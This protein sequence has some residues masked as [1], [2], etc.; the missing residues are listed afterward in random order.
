MTRET[1][2]KANVRRSV[3]DAK[4]SEKTLTDG[5]I[6]SKCD[7]FRLTYLLGDVSEARGAAGVLVKLLPDDVEARQLWENTARAHYNAFKA[8]DK[9]TSEC[10]CKKK[11]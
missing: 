6:I 11:M 4:I 9:F 3:S 5:T 10:E 7:T 1:K 8:R 2:V